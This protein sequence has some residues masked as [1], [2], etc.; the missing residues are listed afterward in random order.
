MVDLTKIGRKRTHSLDESK[1]T[2]QYNAS[3]SASRDHF[4]AAGEYDHNGYLEPRGAKGGGRYLELMNY[5]PELRLLKDPYGNPLVSANG[6]SVPSVHVTRKGYYPSHVNYT[7]LPPEE[8]AEDVEC[9]RSAS[10][11]DG[12]GVE[13]PRYCSQSSRDKSRHPYGLISVEESPAYSRVLDDN[14]NYSSSSRRQFA[15]FYYYPQ[16]MRPPAGAVMIPSSRQRKF[17]DQDLYSSTASYRQRHPSS[18]SSCQDHRYAS[19]ECNNNRNSLSNSNFSNGSVFLCEGDGSGSSSSIIR[20]RNGSG[21]SYH[22]YAKPGLAFNMNVNL[23]A[24]MEDISSKLSSSQDTWANNSDDVFI[25][26]TVSHC[27]S[28]HAP[29]FI[30]YQSHNLCTSRSEGQGYPEESTALVGYEETQVSLV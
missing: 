29:E 4:P 26:D 3:G 1:H 2:G 6:A 12:C 24:P 22:T 17:S 28:V 7:L 18:S 8:D 20:N 13:D 19:V 15:D 14:Q 10:A 21:S 23:P 25:D 9:H 30:T 11:S 27:S 5:A 16:S